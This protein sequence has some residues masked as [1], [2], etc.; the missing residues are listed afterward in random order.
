MCIYDRLTRVYG[1]GGWSIIGLLVIYI[2]VC[3]NKEIIF[4]ILSSVFLSSVVVK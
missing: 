1:D 4:E 3:N 2:L